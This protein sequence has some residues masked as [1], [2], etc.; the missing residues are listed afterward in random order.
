MEEE[1]LLTF[2]GKN[3]SRKEDL[4]VVTE[5]EEGISSS[6]VIPNYGPYFISSLKN[7]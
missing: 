3:T 6:E 2:A 5:E 1:D 7:I 4:M